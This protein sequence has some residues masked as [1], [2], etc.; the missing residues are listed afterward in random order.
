MIRISGLVAG[1]IVKATPSLVANF[2]GRINNINI[3]YSMQFANYENFAFNHQKQQPPSQAPQMT[4]GGRRYRRKGRTGKL[5][6]R[7][8][9]STRKVNRWFW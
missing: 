3:I 4:K 9:R 1:A 2:R 8:R 7:R 5:V 6:R